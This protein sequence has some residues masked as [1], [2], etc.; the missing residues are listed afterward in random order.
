[1]SV[2]PLTLIFGGSLSEPTF[3]LIWSEIPAVV[4]PTAAGAPATAKWRNRLSARDLM[5]TLKDIGAS[6]A[7]ELLEL[8]RLQR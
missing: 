6:R 5:E 1:M 7:I 2:L 4:I 8:P 3:A